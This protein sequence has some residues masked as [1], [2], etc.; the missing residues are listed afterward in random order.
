MILDDGGD[1]TLLATWASARRGCVAARG[2]EKRGRGGVFAS[3]RKA[4]GW[5][6]SRPRLKASRGN[7]HRGAS[8]VIQMA[9]EKR[10][11]SRQSTSTTRHQVEVRQ[12][13][14]R[15]ESLSTGI[16]RATDVMIAGKVRWSPA[17][18][19]WA[20]ADPGPAR[21]QAQVWVTEIRPDLRAAGGDGRL[22]GGDHG[23][24]ADK[25]DIFV[26]ATGNFHVITHSTCGA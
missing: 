21:A 4:P 24:R 16:K 25:A 23:L 6:R 15:R 12:H 9:K 14:R 17:T 7:H 2:S 1:A 20:R 10:R 18:A 13:L 3:V 8:P 22:Q 5:Y 19:R 11:S 26:T